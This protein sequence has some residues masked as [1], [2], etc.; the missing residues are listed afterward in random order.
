MG[1]PVYIDEDQDSPSQT[2]HDNILNTSP[3]TLPP[4]HPHRRL[5]HYY[6]HVR[7]SQHPHHPSSS[8]S[9]QLDHLVGFSFGSDQAPVRPPRHSSLARVDT[10]TPRRGSER[11]SI[12]FRYYQQQQQAHHLRQSQQ[13]EDEEEG[14]LNHAQ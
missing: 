6:Q 5:T 10:I 14:E 11:S 13:Q 9:S 4:R 7:H 1:I 12:L 8:P 2:G 3:P